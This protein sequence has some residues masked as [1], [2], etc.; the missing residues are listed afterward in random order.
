VP[1]ASKTRLIEPKKK[2]GGASKMIEKRR[3]ILLF[4]IKI[5]IFFILYI[6]LYAFPY[7]IGIKNKNQEKEAPTMQW[8]QE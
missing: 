2:R 1:T 3:K 7:K 6:I 8:W 5:N 4:Y